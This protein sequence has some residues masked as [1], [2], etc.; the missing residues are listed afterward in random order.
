[1]ISES[2]SA[3]RQ[4]SRERFNYMVEA[5]KKGKFNAIV[6]VAPDR[7]SR[8]AVDAGIILEFLTEGQLKYIVTT[9]TDYEP[10][11]MSVMTLQFFMM[12]AKLDN[13]VKA[14]KVK[15]G[16]ASKL[17]KG[18]YPCVAPQGYINTKFPEKGTNK[19]IKDPKRFNQI[20]KLWDLMLTG[21]YTINELV[22]IADKQWKYKSIQRIKIGGTPISRS[23]LYEIFSNPFYYGYFNY[24]GELYKG[25]HSK[26]VEKQEFDRVQEILGRKNKRR[27]KTHTHIFTGLIKCPEC[28]CSIT[29]T[30][31]DKFYP[32]T[33][34]HCAYDYYHCSRRNKTIKCIQPS[35]TEKQLSDQIV[36][37]LA[38]I[39][40]PEDFKNWAKTYLIE[41]SKYEATTSMAILESQQK[42]YKEVEKQLTELLDMRVS[43]EINPQEYSMKKKNLEEVRD[44]LKEALESSEKSRDQFKKEIEEVFDFA[45]SARDK[46]ENG[47]IAEKREV[48]A[49]LGQNLLLKDGKLCIDLKKPFLVFKESKNPEYL[50]NKRLE[51]V[52]FV[53]TKARYDVSKPDNVAWLPRVDSNHRP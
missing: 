38:T 6:T 20:R 23:G 29:A 37:I 34:N 33:N 22:E 42:E 2:R 9:G 35:I 14:D 48:L 1:V 49:N 32:K 36:E 25:A 19:I 51:L 41:K 5:I 47:S 40:I 12:N 18:W 15:S 24:N 52:E 11:P 45:Y 43:K 27:P 16:L 13:M 8:N 28:G 46:M 26:M 50:K 10:N 21:S 30:H 44:L 39:E 31:K 3:K 7:L 53:T 17:E 4:G